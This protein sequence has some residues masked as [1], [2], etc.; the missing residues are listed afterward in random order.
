MLLITVHDADGLHDYLNKQL[1]NFDHR[2]QNQI[3]G[4]QNVLLQYY[5]ILQTKIW[6]LK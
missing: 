6:N 5:G 3:F 2:R 4:P 1:S